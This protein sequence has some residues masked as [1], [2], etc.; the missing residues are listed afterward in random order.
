MAASTQEL[1][2]TLRSTLDDHHDRRE[3]LV[4]LSRD[5]TVASQADTSCLDA[6]QSAYAD[7]LAMLHRVSD[8]LEGSGYYRYERSV[9]PALEEF[10]EAAVYRH[11]LVENRLVTL[12]ELCGEL[13]R[14]GCE[15]LPL[16]E[17]TYLLG[18]AD[19]TGELMRRAINAVASGERST[20]LQICSFLRP[21][22]QSFE[23]LTLTEAGGRQLGRKMGTMHASMAKVEQACCSVS[24]RQSEFPNARGTS[25][26]G[27]LT[28]APSEDG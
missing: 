14:A 4:K 24:I 15:R 19:F 21:L 18:V 23:A 3:R 1:F 6:T 8:E 25:I 26:V 7:I 10:V 17:T 20:A 22:V 13:Q 9:A 12:E 5:I 28:T 2:A 11:Y 27:A 16:T